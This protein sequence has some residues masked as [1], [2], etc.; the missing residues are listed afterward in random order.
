MNEAWSVAVTE[1]IGNL[2]FDQP[3]S[4][5]NVLT[6]DNMKALDAQLDALAARKDL[7][8]LLI[9]SPKNRIFIAGAD[10]RE[11]ESIHTREDAISKA[12]MGKAV[13]KKLEDLPFPTICVINGACLGGGY[14]LALSCRW[15]VASFSPAVKIGLPE[16]NLGIL[17]GFGGSIRLPRLLGLMKALPLILT[18]RICSAD[19]ALKNGMVDA[20]FPD[21]T[22]AQDA[23][24]FAKKVADGSLKRPH[25]K[26][27]WMSRFLEDT[28]LG[29]SVVFGRAKKDVLEKPAP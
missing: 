19:E 25:P 24:A 15:R 13:F 12:E 6:G 8:A 14:E 5:V 23:F 22:L 3:A 9:S 2:V 4:E 16:V 17:P 21:L 29:R 1:G 27:N 7:K 11:I 18:G 26:K 20:L 28:P 10:I